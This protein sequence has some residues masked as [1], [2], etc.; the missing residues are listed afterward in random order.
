M[1]DDSDN[2][3]LNYKIDD[4]I[5]EGD[6]QVRA[7]AK[8]FFMDSIEPSRR[9]RC[10]FNPEQLILEKEAMYGELNPIGWSQT[11]Q[12]YAYTKSMTYSVDLVFTR[13]AADEL[14]KD[15]EN[16]RDINF[17]T[18]FF[19]YF[20]HSADAG[21]APHRL[22]FYCP[23]TIHS[24]NILK[25]WRVTYKRWFQNMDI[26]EYGISLDLVEDRQVWQSSQD[27]MEFGLIDNTL[28]GVGGA[29]STGTRLS[30]SSDLSK[31]IK[32]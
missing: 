14:A 11:T 13:R 5:F 21:S 25:K 9:L 2:Y 8:A 12:Q 29:E 30:V 32:R 20:L 17:A 19:N 31:R 16:Y 15:E 4:P 6:P 10:L 3:L 24:L 26:A 22:M 7:Y 1:A 28:Y 18:R 23:N 27:A